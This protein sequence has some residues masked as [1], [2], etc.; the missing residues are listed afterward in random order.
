MIEAELE[1][2]VQAAL[3]SFQSSASTLTFFRQVSEVKEHY[4][5]L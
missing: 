2:E 4:R 5:V 1:V 3:L